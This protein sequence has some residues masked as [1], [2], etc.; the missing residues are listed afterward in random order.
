MDDFFLK[1]LILLYVYP[2]F[3]CYDSFL[4]FPILLSTFYTLSDFAFY[5]LCF[6]DSFHQVFLFSPN[7]S[8]HR[9][10]KLLLQYCDSC[11]VSF[12]SLFVV[13]VSREE[14]SL[15]IELAQLML[16]DKIIVCQFKE[17]DRIFQRAIYIFI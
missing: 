8:P 5:I 3:P 2:S 6:S 9:S 12:H 16:Q 15:L 14:V 13:I 1:L 11:V 4:F 17:G 7:I 10:E